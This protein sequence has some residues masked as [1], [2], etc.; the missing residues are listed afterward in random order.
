MTKDERCS[1]FDNTIV[2]RDTWGDGDD[3]YL[4]EVYACGCLHSAG[5][6]NTPGFRE[7]WNYYICKDCKKGMNHA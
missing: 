2:S 3:E 4:E 7:H 6:E 1:E 5:D